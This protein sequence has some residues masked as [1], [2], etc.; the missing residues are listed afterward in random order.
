M[1]IRSI[2]FRLTLWYALILAV[3]LEL[4]GVLIQWSLQSRLTEEEN[5]QVQQRA[6]AFVRF[7][8]VEAA[9]F[10]PVQ[11]DDEILEFCQALP[12]S[13]W[14]EMKRT[15]GSLRLQ[16]PANR[17][18]RGPFAIARRQLTV[19]GEALEVEMGASVGSDRRTLQILRTLLL[20]LLPVV[21][22]LACAGGAWLSHRALRPVAEMTAAA[23]QIGI[24]NL[25]LRLAVSGSGDELQGLAET[26]NSM[27]DRLEGA[28]RTLSQFAA[29]ASHE[30][31]TPLAVV[32]TSAELA[33][34]RA[35]EPEA[36][37]ES[38]A[39][40]AA[41]TERMT[42]LV[43]D[44]LFLARGESGAVEMP[45]VPMDL[46]ILLTETMSEI[47]GLAEERGIR[48]EGRIAGEPAPVAGNDPALVAGN[49]AALRRLFLV[50]LDNAL[51]F[52]PAGG[53]VTVD[54]EKD[55]GGWTV[56]VTDTGVGIA[57]EDLPHIF[58]RFYRAFHT[59]QAGSR[60]DTGHGLGLSLASSIAA[61]HEAIIDVETTP[62][63]GSC[64]RVRFAATAM[65]IRPV[66]D[67]AAVVS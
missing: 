13:S 22:L 16:Y 11:L 35:R 46:R 48:L 20:S 6:D 54:L 64:F 61:A 31:R 66:P 29:D 12:A 59:R 32:R 8:A 4:F 28:V 60:S 39:E 55:A 67:G 33:L 65:T 1:R 62:G 36:Y 53:A 57:A 19:D 45:R 47:R 17:R 41:E 44:L 2:G 42:Q 10:P 7:V 14:L 38:L 23:R 15:D 26:W 49:R 3:S 50:L 56:A 63:K 52:T 25:S 43:E 27:L 30:L 34:R 51:K 18:P 21:L 5:E 9:E 58:R 37:R 24:S 40:I